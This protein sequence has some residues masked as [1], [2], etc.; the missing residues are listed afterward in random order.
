MDFLQCKLTPRKDWDSSN[1]AVLAC[2]CTVLP[3][4]VANV[5]DVAVVVD[6]ILHN[7]MVVVVDVDNIAAYFH[8][9]H[10]VLSPMNTEKTRKELDERR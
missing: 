6:S 2:A 5:V 8:F 10:P 4:V 7:R 9:V 3:F 1:Q